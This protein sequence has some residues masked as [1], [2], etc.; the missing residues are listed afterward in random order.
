MLIRNCYQKELRPLPLIYIANHL[1]MLY[2]LLFSVTIDVY[3]EF[4]INSLEA[5]E[6]LLV[7]LD[8]RRT[9]QLNVVLQSFV[10]LL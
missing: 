5:P 3:C 1:T 9:Q 4:E 6:V 2:V 10:Y 8:A 7:Y